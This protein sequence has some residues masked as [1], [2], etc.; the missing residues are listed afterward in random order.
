MVSY[1]LSFRPSLH[2]GLLDENAQECSVIAATLFSDCGHTS[3]IKKRKM[4][5]A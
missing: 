2:D 3:N 5:A 4:A 1:R